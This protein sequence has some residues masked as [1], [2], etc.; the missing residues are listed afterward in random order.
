MCM[1]YVRWWWGGGGGG[2]GGGGVGGGQR[3]EPPPPLASFPGRFGREKWPGNCYFRCQRV[4]RPN[5]IS[6]RCHITTVNRIASCVETLQSR[7]FIT[8]VDRLI[9]LV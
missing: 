9:T 8:I 7:P 1:M 4:G 2:G 3:L 6:D 5:Q